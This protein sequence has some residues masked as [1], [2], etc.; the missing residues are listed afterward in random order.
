MGFGARQLL[1]WQNHR[2]IVSFPKIVN[3]DALVTCPTL[4]I[5]RAVLHLCSALEG[6]EMG[7]LDARHAVPPD[8][9]NAHPALDAERHRLYIVHYSVIQAL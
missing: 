3:G 9:F 4:L 7:H 6:N 5:K 1:A 2:I 8:F